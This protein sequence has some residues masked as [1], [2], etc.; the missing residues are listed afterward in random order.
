MLV[1]DEFEV[2]V[3]KLV[4]AIHD[5]LYFFQWVDKLGSMVVFD[6]VLGLLELPVEIP[7]G[8][9]VVVDRNGL[10]L[11]L[12]CGQLLDGL[13]DLFSDGNL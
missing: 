8:D 11:L 13:F 4:A 2:F 6:L 9:D 3:G 7:F 5:T 1:S 12:Q 10:H